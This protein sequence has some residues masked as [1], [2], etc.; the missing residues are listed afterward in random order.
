MTL[1]NGDLTLKSGR[2]SSTE[3]NHDDHKRIERFSGTFM[4]RFTLPDQADTE[5]VSAKTEEGVLELVTPKVEKAK[6]QKIT[7]KSVS[8]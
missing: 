8:E 5:N 4:R 2:E 7:A 3:D 6:Q 1:E